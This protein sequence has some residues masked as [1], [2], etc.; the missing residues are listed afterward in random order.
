[1]EIGRAEL[2]RDFGSSYKNIE[3]KNIY[4]PIVR[5][6]MDFRHPSEYDDLIDIYVRPSVV[7]T[8]KFTIDYKVINAESQKLLV[9]G[10]TVHCCTI[11]GKRPCQVDEITR[12]LFEYYDNK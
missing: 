1:F 9:E 2:I 6:E 7:E 3:S 4:H 11:E 12:A 10:F 5:L 8:V